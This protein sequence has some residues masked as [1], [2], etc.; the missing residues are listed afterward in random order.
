[1][2]S[3]VTISYAGFNLTEKMDLD[4]SPDFGILPDVENVFLDPTQND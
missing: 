2:I 3:D 4:E 1:M